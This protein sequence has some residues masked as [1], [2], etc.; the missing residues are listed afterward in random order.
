MPNTPSKTTFSVG[1]Q[2][3]TKDSATPDCLFTIE[4]TQLCLWLEDKLIQMKV[5]VS[6]PHLGNLKSRGEHL[7]KTLTE[8]QEIVMMLSQCQDKVSVSV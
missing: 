8:L 5:L 7:L 1:F 2:G 6:S 3:L 4:Q